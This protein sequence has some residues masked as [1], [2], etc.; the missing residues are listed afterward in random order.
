VYYPNLLPNSDDLVYDLLTR[1]L[2]SLLALVGHEIFGMG[3]TV[4]FYDVTTESYLQLSI[5]KGCSGLYSVLIFVSAFT[6][7]I[8]CL[9]SKS[10]NVIHFI[11][12]T[13]GILLAYISNIMRMAIIVM[14]GEYYGMDALLWTHANLGPLIFL[15][16]SLIFW[17]LFFYV[18]SK[19]ENISY[20]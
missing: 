5:T 15:L 14:V 18:N 19:M 20:Y 8:V 7:Y 4:A 17:Q 9:D 16:W 1:P 11:F 6:S 10:L 13:L 3:S 2:V 12:I